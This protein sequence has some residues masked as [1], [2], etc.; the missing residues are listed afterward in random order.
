MRVETQPK[1]KGNDR[2]TPPLD[3]CTPLFDTC[4]PLSNLRP[5]TKARDIA[6]QVWRPHRPFPRFWHIYIEIGCVKYPIHCD[7]MKNQ[8]C[9]NQ[10]QLISALI[11]PP[12][13]LLQKDFMM[14]KTHMNP[15]FIQL[16]AAAGPLKIVIIISIWSCLIFEKSLL[17]P[18]K[19]RRSNHFFWSESLWE[20][21]RR[22]ANK[23]SS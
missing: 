8:S 13:I 21:E 4:T 14:I 15:D 23:I 10:I 1:K 11:Q 7:A 18:L 3:R 19:N 22:T 5:P 16:L 2:C 9:Y 12:L 20:S 17:T 6:L